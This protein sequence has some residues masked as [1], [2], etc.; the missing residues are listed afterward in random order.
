MTT[1]HE[2]PTEDVKD[3]VPH[4]GEETAPNTPPPVPETHADGLA[5]TVH[6]L[7]QTV[8]SLAATVQSMIQQGSDSSPVKKPWTHWK[9][10]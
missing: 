2:T 4:A 7:E 1:E 8:E 3:T 9:V 5:E 10:S 6:K